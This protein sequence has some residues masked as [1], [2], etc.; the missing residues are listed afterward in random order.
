MAGLTREIHFH[1]AT[2]IWVQPANLLRYTPLLSRFT[3]VTTLN[4]GNLFTA[5]FTAASLS[6]CFK[7]FIA[8]VRTLRLYHPITRPT[9]LIQFILLFSSAVDIQIFAPR[10]GII[11]EIDSNSIPQEESGFTGILSL[12]GFREKWPEF[13]AL[14]SAHRLRFQKLRLQGCEF[15]TSVPTQSL[16]QAVSQNVSSLHLDGDGRRGLGF[17]R[18]REPG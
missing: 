18:S 9:S 12:I 13:F 14:L 17:K 8:G 5:A 16:L 1:Q 11:D 15:D 3:N 4:F 6:K 7:P 10:W 2:R